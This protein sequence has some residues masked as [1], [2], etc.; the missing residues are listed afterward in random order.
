VIECQQAVRN[1]FFPSDKNNSSSSHQ[2][3]QKRGGLKEFTTPNFLSTIAGDNIKN[4]HIYNNKFMHDSHITQMRN[5][6]TILPFACNCDF[7][8][9]DL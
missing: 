3:A 4:K 6:M 2:M 1:K 8:P 7:L 5:Q 9:I